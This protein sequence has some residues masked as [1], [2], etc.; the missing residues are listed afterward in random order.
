MNVS[1]QKS[2]SVAASKGLVLNNVRD[3][4]TKSLAVP[5]AF[6]QLFLEVVLSCM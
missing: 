1:F 6:D 5:K 3:V 2:D 4:D